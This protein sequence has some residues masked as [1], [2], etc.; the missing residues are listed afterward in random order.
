MILPKT[1]HEKAL[2]EGLCYKRIVDSETGFAG[3]L[4]AKPEELLETFPDPE[5]ITLW[6]CPE[7][8]TVERI[9]KKLSKR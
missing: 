2:E 3:L 8:S 9:K 5:D 7:D 4:F 1:I 6:V